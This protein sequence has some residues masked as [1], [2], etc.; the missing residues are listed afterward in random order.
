MPKTALRSYLERSCEAG[1][2]PSFLIQHS[3]MRELSYGRLC[4][5]PCRFWWMAPK[6]VRSIPTL[7]K[8]GS[9]NGLTQLSGA[10]QFYSHAEG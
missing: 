9:K 3:R 5:G 1:E 6:D 8:R 4:A 7:Y 2:G 10:L